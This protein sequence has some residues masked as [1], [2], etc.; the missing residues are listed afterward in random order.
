MNGKSPFTRLEIYTENITDSIHLKN[1]RKRVKK[2]YEL[3]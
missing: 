1:C 2:R 3:Q